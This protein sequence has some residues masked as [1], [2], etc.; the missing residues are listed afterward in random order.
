MGRENNRI[1]F[2]RFQVGTHGVCPERC[3]L[4]TLLSDYWA[5]AVRAYEPPKLSQQ[6]VPFGVALLLPAAAFMGN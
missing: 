1:R 2:G 3:I 5:H 4:K 6:N